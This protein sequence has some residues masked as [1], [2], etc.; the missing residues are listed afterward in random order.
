[1]LQQTAFARGLKQKKHEEHYLST[2]LNVL[3]LEVI[4]TI[5]NRTLDPDHRLLANLGQR[6]W[7]KT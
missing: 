2:E 7:A 6:K 5:G 3:L 4:E 1:M